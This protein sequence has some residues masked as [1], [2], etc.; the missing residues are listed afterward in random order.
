MGVLEMGFVFEKKSSECVYM[1]TTKVW[2]GIP[3]RK[4]FIDEL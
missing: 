1:K 4:A 3:L 2:Y